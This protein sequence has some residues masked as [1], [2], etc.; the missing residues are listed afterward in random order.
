MSKTTISVPV[1][2]LQMLVTQVRDA[3][4]PKIVWN[5]AAA[6]MHQRADEARRKSLD[7]MEDSLEEILGPEL[8]PIS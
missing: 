2:M 6:I 7:Q 8:T 4:A 5:E 3:K 1:T